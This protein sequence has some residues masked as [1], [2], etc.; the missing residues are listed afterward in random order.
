MLVVTP[1]PE[2]TES[3]MGYLLRV[4]EANGYP[5]LSYVLASMRGNWYCSAIG[6]LDAGPLAT[7]AGLAPQEVARLTLRP[8]E[9]PR[10][11]I[12]VHGNDLPSYEVTMRRPK[13]CPLCLAEGSV[14]E[15]FWDLAQAVAC[16]IHRVMLVSQCGR[17]QSNLSW[18]RSE[19]KRCRCGADLTRQRARRAAP[20]L[21][22]LMGAMRHLV[23]RDDVVA[24]MPD[25]MLHLAHLDLR[26]LCKLLWVMSGALH[27]YEGGESLPKARSRYLP[28][29]ERVA[30]ALTHWPVGFQAF[31]SK[32]YG[33]ELDSAVELPNF[34]K[35]FN[36]LLIRLIKHD[37]GDGSAYAFLEAQVYRF[38]ARYWTCKAMSRE[39]ATASLM[40]ATTRWGTISEGAEILGLHMATMKK[41]IE[42]GRIKTRTITDKSKRNIVVDLDWARAQPGRS[43]HRPL[44]PRQ[45]AR[46]LGI[47]IGAVKVLRTRGLIGRSRRIS[48]NGVFAKEDILSLRAMITSAVS[49]A[50]KR[51]H[52]HFPTMDR[53]ARKMH[54]SAEHKATLYQAIL[55]GRLAVRG[56]SNLTPEQYQL[57]PK[58]IGHIIETFTRDSERFIR[59]EEANVRLG[60]ITAM[61]TGLVDAGYLKREIFRGRRRLLRESV[62]SFERRFELVSGIARRIKVWPRTVSVQARRLKIKLHTVSCVQHTALLVARKDVAAIEKALRFSGKRRPAL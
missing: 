30:S 8:E 18:S 54:L 56:N 41:L 17:C 46:I 51:T 19:V 3:L 55:D 59:F 42:T 15:A 58:D 40:P 37:E 10:A 27:Q 52:K 62:D 6:R 60:C 26:R 47:S 53:L 14:C 13:F 1:R 36:W 38:G 9:K 23:Y 22:E 31:L 7:I 28:Q 57:D 21:C 44:G 43:H 12:R 2:S 39:G 11:Y 29:L 49:S 50:P 48:E 4:T 5:T 25:A 16:P 34:R 61:T 35:L 33:S 45:A 20:A 24:P 32:T